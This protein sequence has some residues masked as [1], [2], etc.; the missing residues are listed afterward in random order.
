MS[1]ALMSPSERRTRGRDLSHRRLTDAASPLPLRVGVVLPI[2]NEERLVARTLD[3]LLGA[4]GRIESSVPEWRVVIV[5]DRCTDDSAAVVEQWRSERLATRQ[6]HIEVVT[7]DGAN[8]GAARRTGCDMLLRRWSEVAPATVWLA[9]TDG[10][11]EVPPEWLSSQLRRRRH[12]A[13]V[14][15]G[16]VAV[17]EWSDRTVELSEEWRRQY[18]AE[19]LPVHGANLG[20]DGATYRRLGGFEDLASGEDRALVQRAQDTGAVI[21]WDRSVLV[22]TSSRRTAR[23]PHGFAHAL[24]TIEAEVGARR[25]G[26]PV[27]V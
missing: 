27:A 2:H 10:D 21:H 24:D 3:G 4:V 23:A 20:L 6:H 15:V 19:H 13:E 1:D 17:G 18:A 8:V 14:W 11:S 25:D 16:G 26:R 12:G 7:V 9:T 22:A 5:L